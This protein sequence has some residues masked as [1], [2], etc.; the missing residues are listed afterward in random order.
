MAYASLCS[1]ITAPDTYWMLNKCLLIKNGKQITHMQRGL[2]VSIF[3]K[4]KGAVLK[5]HSSRL[6][7]CQTAKVKDILPGIFCTCG[8]F[9][10]T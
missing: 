7:Y 2:H 8:R 6:P 3:K 5:L 4:R 10:C 1:Q 9:R